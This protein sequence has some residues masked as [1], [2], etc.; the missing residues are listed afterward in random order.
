MPEVE[1]EALLS[2]LAGDAPCGADLEYDPAFLG[3]QEAGAGKPEQQYGDT[4]IPPQEP[5]WPLV[6]EKALQLAQRTRD[7]RVAVWLARSGARLSGLAGAVQGLQLARGLIERHWDHV[8]PQLDAADHNDPTARVSALT[9]LVHVGAGLADLRA[10][11]LNGKRGGLTV[12]DIELALGHVDPV[13]GESVPSED[14]VVQGVSAA[15]AESPQLAAHMSAGL[16]AVQGL[17]KVLEQKLEASQT[18]DFTP[19][20]K[21][22]QRVAEAAARATGKPVESNGAVADVPKAAALGAISSREDV[23]RTLDRVCEWIERN[24]PTNP[25]PLLIRRS[26]RLMTK[27]F[28]DI[29][30]DLVP[31]GIS[32]IEKL[33]GPKN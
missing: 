27:N 13:A 11:S 6:H 24:E 30:R 29:I 9:P 28:I 31:D 19:L 10:A 25:A 15:I 2:P 20:K 18:P 7:L 26:Q 22:L 17:S 8:H 5:D 32:Q 14:G 12:R 23:I 33:A 21:V 1:L 16:D 3:L 4:V